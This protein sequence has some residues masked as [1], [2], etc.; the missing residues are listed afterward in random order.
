[1]VPMVNLEIIGIFKMLCIYFHD[2]KNHKTEISHKNGIYCILW[3]V[4]EF[5]KL[6]MNSSKVGH[7][8]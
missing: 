4:T 6:W 5:V 8:T 7:Y 2:A 3:N 1:M